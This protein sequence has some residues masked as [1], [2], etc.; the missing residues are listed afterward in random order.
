[1][2]KFLFCLAALTLAGRAGFAGTGSC[3]AFNSKADF[4]A[5]NQDEGKSL[6]AIETFGE[7]NI[8]PL[9]KV[10]LPAPLDQDPNTFFGIGFPNGLAA[11]NLAI[12]D[13]V[14]PGE[15]PP[16]L[17]P[18]GSELALYVIGV[19]F[20]EASQNKVGSDLFSQ[21]IQ[22]SVDLVFAGPRYSGVGFELSW[23]FDRAN[24]HVAIYNAAGETIALYVFQGP[25]QPE[26]QTSF[27]GVWCNQGIARINIYDDVSAQPDAIANI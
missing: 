13:N 21:K 4:D 8:P 24:W 18:S 20:F 17:N 5:F 9:G 26:P 3:R 23:F 19:G 27:F 11:Q 12:W 10:P 7:S 1:M 25:P 2:F 14:T 22:A 6:E 16:G 15:D